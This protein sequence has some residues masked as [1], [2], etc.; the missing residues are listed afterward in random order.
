MHRATDLRQLVA[1][2]DTAVRA[3]VLHQL[4]THL[5][6]GVAPGDVR[7]AFVEHLRGTA[8]SH[9]AATSHGTDGT[10]SWYDAWDAWVDIHRGRPPV[11]VGRCQSCRGRRIDM[12][13]GRPC[14]TCCGTG[15]HR[16]VEHVAA[17]HAP[18]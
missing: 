12:R 16:H 10:V 17:R 1:H 15:R 4:V 6:S 2:F 9:D 3:G 7:D 14:R 5:P 8:T 11:T 18:R 13:M